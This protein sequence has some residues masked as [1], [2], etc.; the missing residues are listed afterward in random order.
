MSLLFTSLSLNHLA[1]IISSAAIRPWVLL[2]AHRD[3]KKKMSATMAAEVMKVAG[4]VA[5]L[6][7]FAGE[8]FMEAF[9]AVTAT[10]VPSFTFHERFNAAKVKGYFGTKASDQAKTLAR[11]LLL[12]AA[13]RNDPPDA[14]LPSRRRTNFTRAV[15]FGFRSCRACRRP[16]RRR[17]PPPSASTTR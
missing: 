7:Q 8:P 5:G 15:A 13:K 16:S 17:M 11:R 3:K 4:T 1:F 2:P 6:A 10:G 9:M 14:P 12:E